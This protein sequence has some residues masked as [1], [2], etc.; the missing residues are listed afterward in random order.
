MKQ[1]V[2]LMATMLMCVFTLN[3]QTKREYKTE[4]DGFEWYFIEKDGKKGAEDKYGRIIIPCE[5]NT[6]GYDPYE[7]MSNPSN[8][9]VDGLKLTPPYFYARKEDDYSGKYYSGIYSQEGKLIIPTNRKYEFIC[10]FYLNSKH[11]YFSFHN[12]SG[13]MGICDANGKEIIF[14]RDIVFGSGDYISPN[15]HAGRF[16][17]SIKKKG[18]HGIMDGNGNIVIE[19]KSSEFICFEDKK[20]IGKFVGVINGK[21]V[22]L[23]SL[24]SIKTTTNLLDTNHG[25]SSSSHPSSSS[26]SSSSSRNSTSGNTAQSKSSN[27]DPGLKYAGTYTESP[28]GYHEEAGRYTDGIGGGFEKD[29]KIYDDKLIV[30]GTECPFLRT[31]GSWRI[32]KDPIILSGESFYYVDE[33]FNMKKVQRVPNPF[34]G[35]TDTFTYSMEKGS[36]KF[37]IHQNQSGGYGGGTVSGGSGS[38]GSTGHRCRLCNGTGRKIS[39][40]HPG[41]STQTKWCNECRKRVHTGHFHTNCDL[42]GGSGWI[43]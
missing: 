43:K 3:A 25:I 36:V 33:N 4:N 6:V 24:S 17:Y 29:V 42:C 21:E 35:G 1:K 34:G 40:V 7:E 22:I 32:Y 26:S 8:K 12:E 19:P 5:Y 10:G 9:L 2:I 27:T 20:H 41:N 18:L 14:I 30:M 16:F 39:Q 37:S 13:G 11:P 23:G 38:S 31:S 15:Y 28:Q